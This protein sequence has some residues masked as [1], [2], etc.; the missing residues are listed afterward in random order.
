MNNQHYP[1]ALMPLPYAYDAL[2]PY[3]D[4]LTMQLH[5][6]RH[7][8]TYVDNLN[9]ALAGYPEFHSWTLEQLLTHAARLPAAIRT[10]VTRNAGGVWNHDFFF[11]GMTP[12]G[13]PPTGPLAQK[14]NRTFGDFGAFQAQFKAKALEVF[15]SGYAWLA[16]SPGPKSRAAQ[17]C[18]LTTANQDAP[19]AAGALPLAG[20][21]VWEHAYYLKHYNLRA[22]YVDSWL[23]VANFGM[24]SRIAN[25]LRV[26]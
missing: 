24:A 11:K 19:I 14:I 9:E 25:Q 2:E 8:K 7:L 22:D 6:D 20:I 5:H 26:Q 17:L 18:F 13:S 23:R 12:G 10:A 4:T 1:F 21:D 16:L 3:I 15:G